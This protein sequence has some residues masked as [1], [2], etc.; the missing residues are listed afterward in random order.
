[1]LSKPTIL[2]CTDFN[3]ASDFALKSAET[4]RKK[5]GGSLHVLHIADFPVQWDWLAQD[6]AYLL[7]TEKINLELLRS[8]RQ[9]MA[10]QVRR[11]EVHGTTDV[12]LGSTYEGIMQHISTMK[13]DMVIMG[14]K[15]KSQGLF[16]LGGIVSKVVASSTV[17]VMVTKKYLGSSVGKV[18]GLVDSSHLM[19]P[20]VTATEEMAFLL[21]VEPEIVSLWRNVTSQ[22]HTFLDEDSEYRGVILKRMKE[23][24]TKNLDE[25]SK[26]KVRVDIS[27]EKQIAYHLVNILEEDKVDLAI[28]KRHQKD[29]LQKMLIGSETRRMLELFNGNILVLP[30]K[31]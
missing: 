28:M 2:V 25:H 20:I 9:R 6:S 17:P 5:V 21:S 27:D 15:G 31:P 23:E 18:A 30:P 26:C 3:Q 11:C 16:N 1:M 12:V 29:F 19:K 13:P 22:H 7:Q 24:I 8:L 4:I 14:H 10:E